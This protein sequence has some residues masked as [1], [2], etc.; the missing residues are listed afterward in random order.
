MKDWC[1]ARYIFGKIRRWG[2]I[3]HI[4]EVTVMVAH[5]PIF[6]IYLGVRL[7]DLKVRLILKKFV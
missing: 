5:G 1:K 2:C 6:R 4:A 3:Q 7:K